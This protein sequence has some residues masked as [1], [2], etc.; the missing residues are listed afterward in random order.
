MPTDLRP[1]SATQDLGALIGRVLMSAIYIWSGYDKLMA[2]AGTQ[3]YFA[4]L[5]VPL[6]GAAWLVAVIVELVGGLALLLGIRTRLVGVVLGVWSIATAIAGHS[7]FADPDMQI[8]FMKNVAMAGG[9]A[10]VAVFGAGAY[11]LER[12][13]RKADRP[14]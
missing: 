7:N 13:F 3:A 6:P 12:A 8:H 4:S 10:Y 1:T 5:G 14:G 9:F 11:A 2:A